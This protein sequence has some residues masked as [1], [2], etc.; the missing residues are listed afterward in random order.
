MSKEQIKMTATV[1]DMLDDSCCFRSINSDKKRVLWEL[2]SK[3]NLECGHCFVDKNE[4]NV[5][6]TLSEIGA[7]IEQF[8]D[9]DVG[10]IIISGGE[11][12]LFKNIAFIIEESNRQGIHVDVN[13][14]GLLL[15]S[16]KLDELIH[17]GLSEI[18]I[19]LDGSNS[20][21]HNKQR[22]NEVAFHAACSSI[23]LATSKGVCVDISFT[24]TKNNFYDIGRTIELA[25]ELGASSISV[26]GLWSRG[27]ATKAINSLLLS[28]DEHIR[29]LTIINNYRKKYGE[30]FPI[31]TTRLRK[32]APFSKCVAG[33]SILCIDS[34]GF[35]HPCGHLRIDRKSLTN[36][37]INDVC[38]AINSPD[39][40]EIISAI[41]D[42]KVLC[43]STCKYGNICFGGC[44]AGDQRLDSGIF[45]GDRMCPLF[46][47][48]FNEG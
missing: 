40:Q 3:C 20:Q 39:I 5:R 33:T 31:R 38:T 22:G 9:L 44:I 30:T 36:L 15:S 37:K 21:I 17:I 46:N 47:E 43:S 35:L 12:L 27:P 4:T 8:S 25:I 45:T 32:T 28:E 34:A 24:P 18:T 10:K 19:S 42:K 2:T 7:I 23:K 26:C 16:E 29:L 14:N 11:P 13:T 1:R 48:N 41:N 6:W